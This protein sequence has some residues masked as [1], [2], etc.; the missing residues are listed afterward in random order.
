MGMRYLGC[1]EN[2]PKL[3]VMMVVQLCKYIKVIELGD[4][5][6]TIKVRNPKDMSLH[7]NTHWIETIGSLGTVTMNNS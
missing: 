7:R 2:I 5:S 6:I 4:F 3:V 1:N